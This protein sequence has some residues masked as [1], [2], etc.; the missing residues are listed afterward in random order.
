MDMRAEYTYRSK[1]ECQISKYLRCYVQRG[2]IS[3]RLSITDK[4]LPGD[5]FFL[6]LCVKY[7]VH[8]CRIRKTGVFT[9][10]ESPFLFCLSSLLSIRGNEN[11]SNYFVLGSLT[12]LYDKASILSTVHL[13][14]PSFTL[15]TYLNPYCVVIS[16]CLFRILFATEY[17]WYSTL[18]LDHG[19]YG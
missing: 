1:F 15:I 11:L 17:L 12:L 10:A 14:F 5:V 18:K 4:V 9:P 2:Q 13:C 19:T 6:P 7:S 8:T 16:H 3:K